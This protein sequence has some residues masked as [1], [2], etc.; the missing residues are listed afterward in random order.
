MLFLFLRCSGYHRFTGT[1][2]V[3]SYETRLRLLILHLRG[4]KKHDYPYFESF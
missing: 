3:L 4:R 2:T 1:G